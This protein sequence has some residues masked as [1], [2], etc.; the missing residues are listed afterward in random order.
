MESAAKTTALSSRSRGGQTTEKPLNG[1]PFAKSEEMRDRLQIGQDLFAASREKFPI[2]WP[3][4]YLGLMGAD[5]RTDPIARMGRPTVGELVT[6]ADDLWDPVSDQALRPIPF[7]VRKHRDRVILLV[8]ATCHFYC[9]FCFRRDAKPQGSGIPGQE[10][11]HRILTY[12]KAHPEIEEPIL[13]GGDPFTLS[14]RKLVTIKNQLHEVPS[15]K[16]WRIHSRAPVHFPQR[17]T[18][19]LVANLRSPLPLRLI[20]HF[21][22]PNEIT[23][24]SRRIARLMAK[25][26]IEFKNQAVLLAGVNDDL[27]SQLGLWNG[28]N[29]LGILPHYLHHPDRV[30]GNARFR[31]TITQGLDLFEGLAARAKGP[32]PRYVLDLPDGR[33]KIEVKHLKKEGPGRYSYCHGDGTR[34]QYEDIREPDHKSSPQI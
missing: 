18:E 20:T 11:W 17:I 19:S 6:Q 34:S 2:Q 1:A 31:M 25:N 21:N 28:L 12:L 3:N 15:L 26:Q 9:R 22:H 27:E 32:L 23:G 13:S 30:R 16:R 10:D 33:G 29:E 24:E 7:L 14:D 4:Y 8:T 5:P